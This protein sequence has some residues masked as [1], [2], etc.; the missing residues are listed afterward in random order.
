[1]K[2]IVVLSIISV[3]ILAGCS[4]SEAPTVISSETT[5]PGFEPNVSIT[6]ETTVESITDPA[7]VEPMEP[8]TESEDPVYLDVGA[9]DEDLIGTWSYSI[10]TVSFS[11]VFYD[12]GTGMIIIED[13]A[14]NY[15]DDTA[16]FEYS[17]D[18]ES[19]IIDR[20]PNNDDIAAIESWSYV[21]NEDTM[22]CTDSVGNVTT[23]TR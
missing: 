17:A 4:N 10:D 9:I 2:K 6:E 21:I 7:G 8:P 15:Y 13:T 22:E 14:T 1:M 5:V 19:I 16:T 20:A 11:Y 18:G 23:F 3:M 12:D